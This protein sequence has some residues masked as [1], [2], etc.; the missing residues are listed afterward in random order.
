MQIE[1][2]EIQQFAD[3]VATAIIKSLENRG[4]A[5]CKLETR[6]AYEKTEQLLYS[7]REFEKIIHEK[8]LEIAELKKHGVSHR[9]NS[10]VEYGT[11]CAAKRTVL[12]EESVQGAVHTV[13]RDIVEV[14]KA[15]EMVDKGLEALKN[16]PYIG[17]LKML[18]YDGETQEYI[19]MKYKCSQV[20]ISNN[21][22]RLVNRLAMWLFPNQVVNEIIE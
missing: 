18:Y 2:S 8:E 17:I 3:T 11:H 14:K 7:Y 9:T 4:I 15:L 20:T 19:A 1:N 21:N 6:S 22:K 13:Q 12:P 5:N 16:D 10:V